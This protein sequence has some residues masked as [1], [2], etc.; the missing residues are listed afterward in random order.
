MR[1]AIL[2]F[3]VTLTACR[4]PAPA[5]APSAAALGAELATYRQVLVP[6]SPETAENIARVEKI[7]GPGNAVTGDFKEVYAHGETRIAGSTVAV[8]VAYSGA[9]LLPAGFAAR[10]MTPAQFLRAFMGEETT[11]RA[12]VIAPRGSL[13]V[14]REQVLDVLLETRKASPSDADLPFALIRAAK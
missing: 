5:G 4:K 11:A 13:I 2:L 10:P 14:S 7:K 12:V 1:T 6:L 8:L 9:W 3:A